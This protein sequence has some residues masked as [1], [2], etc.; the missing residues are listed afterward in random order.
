VEDAWGNGHTIEDYHSMLEG[1]TG[2][3]VLNLRFHCPQE[4]LRVVY[5]AS[6]AVLANSGHEPFGLVGLETMAA[7]GIAVTG[8]TGEDY[9]V[10]FYNAIVLE[11]SDPAE[12][13]GYV[14]YLD[15][16]PDERERIRRAG[17]LT[18]SLFTWESAIENLT[19]KLEYQARVQGLLTVPRKTRVVELVPAD[20]EET[21]PAV[22]LRQKLTG[23]KPVLVGSA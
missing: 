3:D 9:A 10:P 7:G 5:A 22:G 17:K 20:G 12:I 14:A 6:D 1:H 11:T 2:A 4:F 18:A 21:G 16:R 13:E 8:C 15:N 23:L 19:K